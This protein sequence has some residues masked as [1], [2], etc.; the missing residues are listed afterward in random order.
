[1]SFH[2]PCESQTPTSVPLG[3]P[4][5]SPGGIFVGLLSSGT[6]GRPIRR[7]CGVTPSSEICYYLLL[8]LPLGVTNEGREAIKLISGA[9]AGDSS[10]QDKGVAHY[11]LS[12]LF[13]LVSLPFSFYLCVPYQ[14]Y[15]KNQL[16][17]LL[18]V[19]CVPLKT[20]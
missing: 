14:I 3:G 1:M 20:P 11:L 2:L 16:P 19:L 15:Q 18:L 9:V 12:L 10:I 17:C 6:P 7:S 5:R 8:N 4:R 13:S